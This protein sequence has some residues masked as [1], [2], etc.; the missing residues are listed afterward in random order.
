MHE[1]IKDVQTRRTN[2]TLHG[3]SV[4]RPQDKPH[5][6]VFHGFN[7]PGTGDAVDF[8]GAAGEPV[9]AIGDGHQTRFDDGDHSIRQN[10]VIEGQSSMG[11][12]FALYAHIDAVHKSNMVTVKEGDLVGRLLPNVPPEDHLHF[13]LWIDNQALSAPT[14]GKLRDLMVMK[15]GL[16]NHAAASGDPRLIVAKK[17]DNPAALDGFIYNELPSRWDHATQSIEVNTKALARWISASATGLPEFLHIRDAVAKMGRT[18][19]YDTKHLSSPGDPRIYAFV[20]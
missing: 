9:F 3:R 12:W 20:V 7:Q 15:L 11:R 6:N 17:S 2:P 13:E 10:I 1:P 8:Y 4:H 5:H 18:A 16:S 14:S 19:T